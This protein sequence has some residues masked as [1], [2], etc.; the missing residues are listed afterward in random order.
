MGARDLALRNVARTLLKPDRPVKS[1]VG[2]PG[3]LPLPAPIR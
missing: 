2:F 3:L 1:P